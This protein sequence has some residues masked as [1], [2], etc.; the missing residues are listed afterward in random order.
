KCHFLPFFVSSDRASA[1]PQRPSFS[2][3]GNEERRVARR[4]RAETREA[5]VAFASRRASL[6]GEARPS[7]QPPAGTG[8]TGASIQS[9][10][11]NARAGPPARRLSRRSR[12]RFGKSLLSIVR[13]F[14]S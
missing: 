9:F 10:G 1:E 2:E 4:S 13:H 8:G 7:V 3:D 6:V 12:H 5:E 11:R 14:R